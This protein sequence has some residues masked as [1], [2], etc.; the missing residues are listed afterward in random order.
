MDFLATPLAELTPTCRK[1]TS[2][3]PST[4]CSV[5]VEGAGAGGHKPQVAG[6]KIFAVASATT[7]AAAAPRRPLG[8]GTSPP[9]LQAASRVAFPD[10][11]ANR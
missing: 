1:F 11:M 10:S 3:K 8:G 9:P 2:S 5:A 6:Q 7:V 4:P